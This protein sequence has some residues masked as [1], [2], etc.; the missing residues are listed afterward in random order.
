VSDGSRYQWSHYL[1]KT[2]STKIEAGNKTYSRTSATP[3]ELQLGD[4]VL[5]R[6]VNERGGPGKDM[7]TL[8][9]S[10]LYRIVNGKGTV[11]FTRLNKNLDLVG[12]IL[13]C[14]AVQMP[15]QR[16]TRTNKENQSEPYT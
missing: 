11:L 7:V 9:R 6:N 10:G 14:P 13:L 8:G 12:D 1:A 5:V 3:V 4:R 15:E 2:N 16:P